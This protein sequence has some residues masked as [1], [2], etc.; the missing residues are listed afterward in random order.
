MYS[1]RPNRND[2]DAM[3]AVRMGCLQH[4]GLDGD[5]VVEKIPTPGQI[6]D[7]H[8]ILVTHNEN[9]V[10][11]ATVTWWHERDGTWLHRGR[12]PHPRTRPAERNPGD[13]GVRRERGGY[14]TGRD[15]QA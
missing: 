4:D 12:E 5:S 10:G 11:Y 1:F 2:A 6:A 9:V 14:R 15:G 3:V 13:G 8:Q 7:G